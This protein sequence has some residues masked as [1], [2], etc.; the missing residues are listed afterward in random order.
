MPSFRVPAFLNSKPQHSFNR[1][2][3]FHLSPESSKPIEQQLAEAQQQS[4]L[5]IVKQ[6]VK[7]RRLQKATP[8]PAYS[9]AEAVP[10]GGIISMSAKAYLWLAILLSLLFIGALSCSFAGAGPEEPTLKNVLDSVIS[11]RGP[12]IVF[13][14]ENVDVD[15]D[16]PSV[17][18]RWAILACGDAYTLPGSIGI[19]GSADCGLPVMALDVYVDNDEQPTA[20]YDPAQIPYDRDSG[21]RRS[22]QNLVQFDS[23]HVLNVQEARLYPFDNYF[24]SSTIR[25]VSSTNETIPFQRVTTIDET[26]SFLVKTVDIESY[27][28]PNATEL[29]SRDIDMY[30]T[31]P[32]N[33]RAFALL[34]FAVSWILTHVTIGHVIM[35]RMLRDIRSIIVHL[36]STGAILVALP[37]IRNSMPDAPGLDGVLID[38]IGFFPQM[39]IASVSAIIILLILAVRELDVLR[40]RGPAGSSEHHRMPSGRPRPPSVPG[41]RASS[42]EISQY[43]LHRRIKHLKG[44]YVFP[45]VQPM[46]SMHRIEGSL[47]LQHRRSKTLSKIMEAGEL[48][49]R[50]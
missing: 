14:G 24:L 10:H 50:Y 43:D 31:R 21:S 39:I 8:S 32:G 29:P 6:P 16:E 33:V 47:D 40:R 22:I 12:G 30:I 26:S 13:T 36:I 49:R 9:I 17:T 45:P 1:L 4:P 44:Q 20:R 38:C 37:Q 11:T 48:P 18:I 19:H 35:A 46:G 34:L 41:D 7:D 28:N 5:R 2:R 23:D 27:S 25:V 15:V 42:K 3:S